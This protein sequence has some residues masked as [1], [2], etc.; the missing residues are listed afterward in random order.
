VAPAD[1]R[2]VLE[3]QL[4]LLT[5]AVEHSFDRPADVALASRP[6]AAGIGPIRTDGAHPSRPV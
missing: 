1:R 4:E 2:P 3:E 6:D 5:E